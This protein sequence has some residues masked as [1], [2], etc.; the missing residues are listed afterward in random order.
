MSSRE[1]RRNEART[2]ASSGYNTLLTA[3]HGT[4]RTGRLAQLGV[5]GVVGVAGVAGVVR[6]ALAS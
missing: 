1:I 6:V 5:V 4:G 2:E 3:R